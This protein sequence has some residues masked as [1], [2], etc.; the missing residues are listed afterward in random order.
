M[1]RVYQVEKPN[2]ANFSVQVVTSPAAADLLVHRD[3]AAVSEAHS[4]GIGSF[5]NNRENAHAAVYVAPPGRGGASLRI[6]YVKT[7]VLSGW[8]RA[9]KLKGRLAKVLGKPAYG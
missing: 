2:Y 8:M 5:V 7:P 6:C 3:D 1:T 4:E 9:H